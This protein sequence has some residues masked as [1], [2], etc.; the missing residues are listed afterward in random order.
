VNESLTFR[1]AEKRIRRLRE[2]IL[3]HEIKYYR[4]SDPQISDYEYDLLVKELEILEAAYPDLI[5]PESPTQR[6]GDQPLEGFTSV[7]HSV[8]MLSLDNCYT[9]QELRDFEERVKKIIPLKGLEYVV[10]LKIDGLGISVIYRDGKFDQAVTRGDGKRGDDVTLNVK[11]IKSLPLTIG[12]KQVVEVRGEIYMPYASFHALNAQRERNGELLFANPRNAA[13]GSIRLLDPKLVAER[14]LDAFLY[15]LYIDGEETKSQWQTLK[16]LHELGFKTNPLSRLFRSLDEVISFYDDLVR[17]RD[18]LAYDAD[19][20][21]IKVNSTVQQRMLGQT[22]KFPRWAISLKFP[23]RQ[24]TT[25]VKDIAIQVGR[26]GALTPVAILEPVQ[27]AGITISRSTLHNEDEIRRKDIRI[28]DTVLIE[29]SGDVIPRVVSVMKERRT[30]TERTFVFPTSCPVCGTKAFR[31]KGEA[32]ARCINPSCA[33]VLRESILHFASRRAMNI[34]GLGEALVDQLLAT[35]L[36]REIPDLYRLRLE[37]LENLERMGRR[38]SQNLLAEIEKSKAND[39]ARLIFALGIR[40]VGERTAQIL[41]S[42]YRSIDALAAATQEELMETEDVGPKVTESVVFFFEQ[43]HNRELIEKLRNLGLNL[44]GQITPSAQEKPLTGKTFVLTGT[45]PGMSR[46]QATGLIEKLG[47][48]VTSSVS[49]KTD[50]LVVGAEP[51][52]KLQKAQQLGITLI[53]VEELLGLIGDT[54]Q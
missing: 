47:G 37:Q 43:P 34:E 45:L 26:T 49:T 28:G 1:Q 51:G 31:P 14:R 3:Y 6:I 17:Q 33:A 48:K 53:S 7:E 24:A 21:V 30:G 44:A 25:H 39:L 4:D 38:S 46:E 32:V 16:T 35:G 5:T 29:R 18:S 50:F 40:Y 8:P 52:S 10:E 23:A 12:L 42:H 9:T 36:V 27:L 2:E 19:G 22:S 13:S 11:T 41:A 54:G 20:I 15:S